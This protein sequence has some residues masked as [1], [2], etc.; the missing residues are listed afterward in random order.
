MN[1]IT[2]RLAILLDNAGYKLADWTMK[3]GG[4]YVYDYA[5]VGT[6]SEVLQMRSSEI[7]ATVEAF[8]A[9]EQSR[10]DTEEENE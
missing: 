4:I 3:D 5:W 8:L 2:E 9:A 6:Y 1:V 10:R 7:K